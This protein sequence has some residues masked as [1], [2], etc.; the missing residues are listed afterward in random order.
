MKTAKFIV[1]ENFPLYSIV[2]DYATELLS[3]YKDDFD[4]SSSKLF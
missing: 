1:L 3:M 2:K 4:A